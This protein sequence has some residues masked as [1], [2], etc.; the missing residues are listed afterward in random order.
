MAWD[1]TEATQAAPPNSVVSRL[2]RSVRPS[3]K[4][5]KPWRN[6]SRWTSRGRCLRNRASE[7]A[8][9]R[10]HRDLTSANSHRASRRKNRATSANSRGGAFASTPTTPW[11]ARSRASWNDRLSSS[12][13]IRSTCARTALI[14][15]DALMSA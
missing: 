9:G 10:S 11:P 6:L 14:L 3:E 15:R 2:T 5:R 12:D 7:P 13:A 4:E 1:Q 8:L